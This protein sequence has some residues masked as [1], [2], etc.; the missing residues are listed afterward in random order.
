M[1]YRTLLVDR[2]TFPS[3]IISTHLIWQTGTA[4]LKRWGL[5]ERVAASNCPLISKVILDFGDFA[6]RGLAPA[7]NGVTE[8]YAPRRKVL[9]KFLV[10]AAVD[11]GAELR[12]G[13]TV[14]EVVKENDRAVGIRGH[15]QGRS[16]VIEKC[17]VVIGADGTHSVVA[18]SVGSSVFNARPALTCWYYSY[19]S[20]VQVDGAQLYSRPNRA[21]GGPPT[22]D[23]LTLVAVGW[24]NREFH[25]FRSD[26][27]GNFLRTLELAPD[28]AERVRSGKREERFVGTADLP[29]FF[30]KRHGPGWVLAGD[31]AYHKDPIT[32]R[33]ISDAFRDAELL[34]EA[35]DAGLSGR[36]TLEH[37]LDEYEQRRNAEVSQMYDFT[38]EFA[39]LAP[40]PDEMRSLLTTIS[41]DQ[42]ETNRYLGMIAGT[43]SIADFF[44]PQNVQRIMG[45]A[46]SV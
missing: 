26:I 13:F 20:G 23:G 34:S 3:D 1:G 16:T 22:N 28:Y 30:R 40:P 11:A 6:L 33:G 32:A 36:K 41:K 31:A 10:D 42:L 39:A 17:R 25:Q 14:E 18:R 46:A 5:L 45:K 43:V 4:H 8:C 12:D 21:M 15:W 37:S 38:C 29:N 35:V 27:E 24:T 9:D 2:T 44:A 7:A 19:W